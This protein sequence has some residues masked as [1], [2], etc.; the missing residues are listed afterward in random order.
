MANIPI[1]NQRG[2][3]SSSGS[4]ILVLQL[5]EDGVDDVATA[6]QNRNTDQDGKQER[7]DHS[8]LLLRSTK[9]RRE[10]TARSWCTTAQE[11]VSDGTM[12]PREYPGIT[13][14]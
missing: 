4:W 14:S 11:N 10:N 3:V 2:M 9:Q 7:H 12:P 5:V 1:N 6:H 13:R 8:P